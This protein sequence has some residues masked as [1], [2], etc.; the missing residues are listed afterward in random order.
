MS[1]Y[2]PHWDLSTIPD[3]LWN[4]E[5]GKRCA[6]KRYSKYGSRAER[7]AESKRKAAVFKEIREWKASLRAELRGK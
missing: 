1:N 4:S 2:Q 7:E 3:E 6:A 5:N